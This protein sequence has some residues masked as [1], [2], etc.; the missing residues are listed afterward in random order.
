M[1]MTGFPSLSPTRYSSKSYTDIRNHRNIFERLIKH[2]DLHGFPQPLPGKDVGPIKDWR[3]LSGDANSRFYEVEKADKHI[4]EGIGRVLYWLICGAD[5]MQP[6][7]AVIAYYKQHIELIQ[8]MGTRFGYEVLSGATDLDLGGP[9]MRLESKYRATIEAWA[10]IMPSEKAQAYRKQSEAQWNQQLPDTP[11]SSQSSN[12][13]TSHG[14]P[15]ISSSISSVENS[16]QLPTKLGINTSGQSAAPGRAIGIGSAI[17]HA[18][19]AARRSESYPKPS[20][21]M[22]AAHST[23]SSPATPA[24]IET[25]TQPLSSMSS[26]AGTA[27]PGAQSTSSTPATPNLAELSV[28]ASSPSHIPV[29]AG[30][31][32]AQQ[33]SPSKLSPPPYSPSYF[34]PV[35]T[36]PSNPSQTSQPLLNKRTES[37]I[38]RKAPPPPRKVYARALYDFAP[39][40]EG[41]EELVFHEGDELEIVKQSEELEADGWCKAKVKGTTRVGLAPLEYIEMIKTAPPKLRSPLVTLEQP[42]PV[43]SSVPHVVP[44]GQLDGSRS[45]SGAG[46]SGAAQLSRSISP[47]SASAGRPYRAMQPPLMGIHEN[48][49]ASPNPD[50]HH[51]TNI[52]INPNARPNSMFIQNSRVGPL[53]ST[54]PLQQ[55]QQNANYPQSQSQHPNIAAQQPAPRY[56]RSPSQSS[57][58]SQQSRINDQNLNGAGVTHQIQP[59]TVQ[60]IA[61]NMVK[62]ST[63]P[64]SLAPNM[65]RPSAASARPGSTFNIA[66]NVSLSLGGIGLPHRSG[67]QPTHHHNNT[68]PSDNGTYTNSGVDTGNSQN[69]DN[70]AMGSNAGYQNYPANSTGPNAGTY[71]NNPNYNTN[72]QNS[73]YYAPANNYNYANSGVGQGQFVAAPTFSYDPNANMYSNSGGY[74]SEDLGLSAGVGAVASAGLDSIAGDGVDPASFLSSSSDLASIDPFYA[75]NNPGAISAGPGT[76]SSLVSPSGGLFTEDATTDT[77][78][79]PGGLTSPLAGLVPGGDTSGGGTDPNSAID[80]LGFGSDFMESPLAGLAP[81]SGSTTDLGGLGSDPGATDMTS[82]LAGLAPDNGSTTDLGGFGDSNADGM[83]LGD[84]GGQMITEEQT[85]TTYM[86]EDTAS[87]G[88]QSSIFMEQQDSTTYTDMGDDSDD[89]FG[90]S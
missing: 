15:S 18:G 56:Q 67:Q 37:V 88:D 16:A 33:N 31:T 87:N 44:G 17:A 64:S 23:F 77:D 50:I 79:A 1:R 60:P 71:Y 12:A 13:S 30:N 69:Y 78:G 35:S 2:F 75:M 57:T 72:M 83:N 7:M 81:S 19:A 26:P 84:S 3:F 38:R 66:P 59:D 43:S 85:Q 63:G 89:G 82:P 76:P 46:I 22:P 80:G 41:G 70:S 40:E 68:N 14:R 24:P 32:S 36:A 10:I 39:E 34:P 52:H 21:H 6:G 62:S 58:G 8:W 25:L 65:R 27:T 28:P 45:L 61:S 55:T 47:P 20:G 49:H 74:S 54:S 53:S 51:N 29:A 48:P 42:Q 9:H 4:G 73:A 5:R 86:E 11:V 90:Y